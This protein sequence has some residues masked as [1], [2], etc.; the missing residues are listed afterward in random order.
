MTIYGLLVLLGVFCVGALAGSECPPRRLIDPC[1]CNNIP[2]NKSTNYTLITCVGFRT[3]DQL[4]SIVP[5]LATLDID[6]FQ[7]YD[8]FWQGGAA[9]ANGEPQNAL[10][11]DFL[12]LN[13]MKE[14]VIVDGSLMPCFACHWTTVCSN[15]VTTTIKIRNSTTADKICT[16]CET[17]SGSRLPWLPCLSKLKH[18]EMSHGNVKSL[19]SDLFMFMPEMN[20]LDF[21]FNKISKIERNTFKNLPAL[22]RLDL[23]H[24][25]IEMVDYIFG[26]NTTL[27]YLDLSYNLIKTVGPNLLPKNPNLKWLKM[28]HNAIEE[29][30]QSDFRINSVPKSLRLLDFTGNPINCSC[31]LRFLNSTFAVSVA[32]QGTCVLPEEYNGS[33][34]RTTSRNLIERCNSAGLLVSRRDARG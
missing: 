21:S 18:L 32:I 20:T 14:V 22:K 4:K 11:A 27:E 9:G 3:S 30:K 16:V 5:L 8:A 7:L 13:K 24:N 29:L 2:L 28:A 25:A 26:Q 10:P 12:T 15:D 34:L 1:I 31:G 33:K 17:G 19:T 23:S 6:S